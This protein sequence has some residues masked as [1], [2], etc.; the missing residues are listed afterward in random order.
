M[1]F[2]M[3]MITT[4]DSVWTGSFSA[5]RWVSRQEQADSVAVYGSD[6]PLVFVGHYWLDGSQKPEPV[7]PN[8]VCLDYSL[9]IGGRLVAYRTDESE[10]FVSVHAGEK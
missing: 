4:I 5:K 7:A 3:S 2:E 6:Q 1:P 8:V 10:P 9:A